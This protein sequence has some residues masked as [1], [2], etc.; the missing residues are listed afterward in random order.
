MPQRHVQIAIVLCQ[1]FGN[2]NLFCKKLFWKH[3]SC[4]CSH[5]NIIMSL[6]GEKGVAVLPKCKKNKNK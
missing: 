3:G 4:L 6:T 5:K 1:N 2:I